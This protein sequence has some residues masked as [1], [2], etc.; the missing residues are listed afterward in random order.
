LRKYLNSYIAHRNRH[1]M[2]RL[3]TFDDLDRCID[4]LE[5]L[6]TEYTLIIE[7]AALGDVVPTIQY[8]WQAPFRV[9]WI[10]PN[11]QGGE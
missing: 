3:P 4:L 1:P 5:Q 6:L 11:P 10:P 8:D 9:A 2:R 7:Q